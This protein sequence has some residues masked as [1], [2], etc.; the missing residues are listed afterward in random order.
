[1][2]VEVFRYEDQDYKVPVGD[3]KEA[4][5]EI[6]YTK[7][8]D[9]FK[10]LG[11]TKET[12]ENDE[13]NDEFIKYQDE[14]YTELFN[15]YYY[16]LLDYFREDAKAQSPRNQIQEG[17]NKMKFKINENW[18]DDTFY[19]EWEEVKSKSVPDSDGSMTDYTWYKGKDEEGNELHIFMFGD[20]DVYT[21]DRDYADWESESYEN[22]EEWFD[23]YRGF[24]EEEDHYTEALALK[25]SDD[26]LKIDKDDEEDAV[27]D[28]LKEST[29]SYDDEI[30]ARKKLIDKKDV[31]DKVKAFSE[32]WDVADGSFP[33]GDNFVVEFDLNNIWVSDTSKSKKNP[34]EI[35]HWNFELEECLTESVS[36]EEVDKMMKDIGITEDDI[37]DFM[38]HVAEE[39]ESFEDAL[40][41]YY[42][43]W[44]VMGIPDS[45][46]TESLKTESWVD[47]DV[48]ALVDGKEGLAIAP[49]KLKELKRRALEM[50]GGKEWL[51]KIFYKKIIKTAVNSKKKENKELEKEIK[52]NPFSEFEESLDVDDD[53]EEFTANHPHDANPNFDRE[54]YGK[55]FDKEG[56]LIP[57]L[58]DEYLKTCAEDPE[59]C[60]DDDD[61]D[62]DMNT[63]DEGL[64]KF[65]P[66]NSQVEQFVQ[67]NSTVISEQMGNVSQTSQ[68]NTISGVADPTI[69]HDDDCNW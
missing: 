65:V 40:E 30:E 63:I 55:Y 27:S 33:Y 26:R 34:P 5:D 45:D 62:W 23:N 28:V 61:F 56:H 52:D 22:A 9:D 37:D 24:E 53:F 39:G 48:D 38:D 54:R 16:E 1:M 29:A 8:L 4:L 49:E 21:P 35:L 59:E 32:E 15:K 18:D 12:L 50:A 67:N 14:H 66:D 43:E 11:F 69:S 2:D 31:E 13:V 6:I 42:M 36:P 10:D 57:E 51:A 60:L 20:K 68:G 46:A 64:L 3:V 19:G 44:D 41:R 17:K 58:E 7:H 47:D 25:E